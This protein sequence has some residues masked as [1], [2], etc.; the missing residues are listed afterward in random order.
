MKGLRCVLIVSLMGGS[1]L[2]SGCNNSEDLSSDRGVEV[3]PVSQSTS[4]V[5]PE[6]TIDSFDAALKEAMD[7]ANKVQDANRSEEWKSV[8]TS[9]QSSITHLQSLS[10]TDPNYAVA[11][12]KIR[13]Y[14]S[15]LDYAQQNFL[16]V[17]LGDTLVDP[18]STP[19]EIQS[20]IDQGANPRYTATSILGE[21][22][23]KLYYAASFGND[24]AVKILLNAG[25]TWDQLTS[26]QLDDALIGASCNGFFF[27]VQELLKAGANPNGLPDNDEKPLAM[28][29]SGICKEVDVNGPITPGTRQHAAIEAALI[30]AG[31]K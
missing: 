7:A 8:V 5:E 23:A 28:S 31:A 15:N 18:A 9:W 13:E 26:A 6:E 16:N 22:T 12:E 20:W 21:Q 3:T 14:Q 2:F 24:H 30:A 17:S 29:G 11:Q 10:E 27:N 25:A 4:L 1:F 19:N